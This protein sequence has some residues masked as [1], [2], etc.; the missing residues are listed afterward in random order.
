M[1]KF[2]ELKKGVC[3][4]YT[5][6]MIQV[7]KKSGVTSKHMK[8]NSFSKAAKAAGWDDFNSPQKPNYNHGCVYVEIEGEKFLSEPTWGAGGSLN[9]GEFTF[10]L[11]HASFLIPYYRGIL[12]HF[13]KDDTTFSYKQF[14]KL[15]QPNFN[16]EVAF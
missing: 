14:I 13:P 3:A 4:D 15:S 5:D 9:T 16:Y 12:T 7:A 11:K 6:F 2:L 1:E 8:I 10:D